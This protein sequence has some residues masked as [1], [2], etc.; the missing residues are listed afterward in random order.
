MKSSWYFYISVLLLFSSCNRIKDKGDQL[1]HDAEQRSDELVD[2]V[3]PH[4]DCTTP[5]TRFNRQ[6]FT[7]FLQIEPT[8]DVKNIYCC[9]NRIGIDASYQF[10]F[11]CDSATAHRIIQQ[12]QL[13]ADSAAIDCSGLQKDFAWWDKQKIASLHS[14]SREVSPGYYQYFWYDATD[15]QAYYFDF[16]L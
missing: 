13:I 7:E 10:A 8:P 12:H 3:I 6:R 5:D 9:D 1:V 4:F 14:Y 2:K 11:T 15:R 16:D